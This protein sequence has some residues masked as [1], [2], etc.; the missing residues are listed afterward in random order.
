MLDPNQ[1]QQQME[2]LQDE[3][4]EDEPGGEKLDREGQ[5]QE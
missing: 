2:Q 5:P 3:Y 4:Y 1:N